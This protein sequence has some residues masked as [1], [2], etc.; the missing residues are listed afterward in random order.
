MRLR[1]SKLVLSALLIACG[2]A[3]SNAAPK[4]MM[5]LSSATYDSGALEDKALAVITDPVG[6]IFLTGSSGD[7]Y[8]SMKYSKTLSPGTPVLYTNGRSGNIPGGIAVDGLGNIVIAGMEMNASLDQAYLVL[9]YSPNF[10]ALISSAA[11]S[12]PIFD[13]A[14]AV[15]TDSQN[16]VYVT[17]FS[18]DTTSDNFYTIK[19]NSSLVQLSSHAW[20]SGDMDQA[21]AMVVDG[22]DVIVAGLTR[23]GANYN[24]R[25]V[26][27]DSSLK[28]LAAVSFD[29]GGDERAAGVAVDSSGNIIATGRQLGATANFLTVKYDSTFQNILS[30]DVY[31]TGGADVPAGIAVDSNDNIIVTGYAANNYLTVKYDS[32]LNIISTATYDGGSADQA[33]AVA[34]DY[35][36]NVIV[37]GQSYG[38]TYDYFTIKYNAS[39]KIT[40]VS[41]LYIGETYTVV[42]KGN[43]FVD[44]SSVAFTDSGISTGAV[45][46]TTPPNQ[47]S[48]PVTLASSVMLG[49]TTVTVSNVNGES[50]SNYALAAARLRK[51][52]TAGGAGSLSAQAQAGPVSVDFAAGT[53]PQ[54]EVVTIYNVAPIAGDVRQVGQALYLA[55]APTDTPLQNISVKLPYN[56]ADLGGYPAAGLGLAYYDDA[57]GWVNVTVTGNDGSSVTGVTTKV[58]AK[59]AVVKAGGTVVVPPGVPAPGGLGGAKVYPNPYKPGSGGDFDSSSMGDGVVFAGLGTSQSFKLTIVDLAGRLVYSKSGTADASGK[60]LWDLKTASGGEA[61]S[62]VYIYMIKSS[63]ELRKGK[64]S[65]IR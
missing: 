28:P 37:T 5:V 58:N 56:V 55:V 24:F 23:A 49:V 59:F 13:K 11:Y 3:V 57:L 34:V 44:G 8:M 10:A 41:P 35:E 64:L 20:D 7:D 33:N 21:A 27:Y 38:S 46:F 50:V 52:V 29:S 63:G 6:N 36:D 12:G 40:E 53:F 18:N 25:I 54:Q 2:A 22:E 15:K 47:L 39:P 51:T 62:G 60:Y 65:I 26:R 14:V 9:K 16:N 31:D 17:G 42:L 30:S 45:S 48:L 61:A 43:G 1:P 19:Y 32:N 4:T